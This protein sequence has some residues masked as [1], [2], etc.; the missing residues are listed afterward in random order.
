MQIETAKGRN[1]RYSYY[2]CRR[3]Q[4][5]GGCSNRRIPAEA[6][7]EWLLSAIG[8]AIF[9]EEN[10]RGLIRDL[11]QACSTWVVDHRQRRRAVADQLRA[12]QDRNEKIYSLF[13]LYGKDTPNLA[14]LTHRLRR[15]NAE[16]KALEHRLGEVDAEQPPEVLI[17]EA[18]VRELRDF[19][20]E[21]MQT[22]DVK[23]LRHFFQ[24]FIRGVWVGN[25]NV[26]IE[27]EPDVLVNREV[28]PSDVIWLP[29]R[30]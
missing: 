23:R 1:R 29:E 27:Y 15:N 25:R 10:L 22:T 9:T 17:S 24:S 13:E 21:I 16:I 26:R 4:R 3:A 2:N 12:I 8:D 7:D 20:L 14:D 11:H 5:D 28:V 18:D 30:A 6:M 19:L